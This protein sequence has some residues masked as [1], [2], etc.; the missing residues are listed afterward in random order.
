MWAEQSLYEGPRNTYEVRDFVNEKSRIGIT[1]Q[2][3]NNVLARH[4]DIVKVGRTTVKKEYATTK[5]CIWGLV[6]DDNNVRWFYDGTKPITK[7]V[8]RRPG[9]KGR[10]ATLDGFK[11]TYFWI[12]D[13]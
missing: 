6:D 4:P 2:G 13:V 5:I 11:Q 3:I 1:W 7:F 12:S 8:I 9:R 10:Q